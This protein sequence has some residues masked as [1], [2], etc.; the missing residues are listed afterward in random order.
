I[1]LIKKWFCPSFHYMLEHQQSGWFGLCIVPIIYYLL[2][3]MMGNY[4]YTDELWAE[5]G[6]LRILL[7]VLVFSVYNLFLQLFKRTRQQLTLQNEQNMLTLQI[8]AM[9]TYLGQLKESQ[10]KTAI[11]RH[12]LRHHMQYISACLNSDKIQDAQEY[13][14]SVCNDI[15]AICVM[16]YCEN[17]T[18]NLLLSSYST[19]AKESNITLDISVDVPAATQVPPTDICVIFANSLENAINATKP[20]SQ[21]DK[22]KIDISCNNKNGKLFLQIKNNYTGSV[23][24]NGDIPYSTKKNHGTG[25]KSIVSVVEKCQGVYSFTAK[26]GVFIMN[27]IL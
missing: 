15:T 13:I 11:Y 9:Q 21:E 17:D 8:N 20:L 24:F 4:N 10:K 7:M 12:D 1:I 5:T 2:T 26:D 3:Y 27:V 23:K 14:T 18:I 16:R 19:K 22:R 6:A 25:I